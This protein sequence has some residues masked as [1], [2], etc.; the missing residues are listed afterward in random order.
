MKHI[1]YPSLSCLSRTCGTYTPKQ[2]TQQLRIAGRSCQGREVRAHIRPFQAQEVHFLWGRRRS[3][4]LLLFAW[5]LG[6]MRL[7]TL[8]IAMGAG[9]SQ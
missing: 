4:L 1:F 6:S 9:E 3:W 2:V 5:L 7:I 8:C